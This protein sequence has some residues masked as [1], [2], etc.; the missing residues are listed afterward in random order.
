MK[1]LLMIATLFTVT[2]ATATS[3]MPAPNYLEFSVVKADYSPSHV[4]NPG[5]ATVTVDFNHDTV[6]LFVQQTNN[7]PPNAMCILSM[8]A[9]VIV[10]LPIVEVKTDSCGIRTIIAKKD[11]RSADGALEVITVKD[12]S[13][14][15]CEYIASPSATYKTQYFNRMGGKDIKLVSRMVLEQFWTVLA[16]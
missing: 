7:C 10:E 12:V 3:L 9:P 5:H 6:T 11:M 14:N 13:Y 1:A 16:E 2:T 15:V 4:T 8:P